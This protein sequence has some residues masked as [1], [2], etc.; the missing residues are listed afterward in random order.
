MSKKREPSTGDERWA[1]FRFSIIGPLL[2]APPEPGALK[3]ALRGL[4]RTIWRHPITG[5]WRTF[6]YS[7]IERWYYRSLNEDDPV[8]VLTRKIRQDHGTH[9]SL[10]RE[11]RDLLGEQYREHPGWSYQLHYDNLK[12]WAEEQPKLGPTPSYTSVRR[13]MKAHG[14]IKRPR[15]GRGNSA[16]VVAAEKRFEALEIRSYESEYAG[17][18]WHLDFHVGSLRILRPDGEWAHPRL[19]GVLDDHSR[20]CC[21]AQW[22]LGET[23]ENL[24]HGLS[25]AFLK[26][27]LPRAFMTDNGRA[28]VAGETVAGLERLGIVHQRTLPYSARTGSRKCSGPRLKGAFWRCSKGG[29]I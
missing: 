18:L 7:T 11:R 8:A 22:Y 27:G 17:Q 29:G 4:A 23:A 28:M 24:V 26:R 12:A 15:R 25:Q 3:E 2:A 19:M 10:C 16:G 9:P 14:L 1:H 6:G 13:F 5:E 21:H 20:L